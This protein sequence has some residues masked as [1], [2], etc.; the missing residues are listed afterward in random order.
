MEDK[1]GPTDWLDQIEVIISTCDENGITT[2]MNRKGDKVFAGSGGYQLIGQSMV[3]C[4]PEGAV[5][6]KF[7]NLLKSQ[8]FNCYTIE[9]KDKKK[10]VYQTPLFKDGLFVGYNEMILSIPDTIPHL[11]RDSGNTEGE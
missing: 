6:E 1:M 11:V 9:I 8:K 2:Y 10:L 3:D 4:H 7:L 5:Q